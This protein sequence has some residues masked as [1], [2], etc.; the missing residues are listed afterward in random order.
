[1]SVTVSVTVSVSESA[2]SF[3]LQIRFRCRVWF[4][5]PLPYRF[6]FLS[7][8]KKTHHA[9]ALAPAP[10]R[11]LDHH[12]KPDALALPRRLLGR[13][14]VRLGVDL[15]RDAAI[16]VVRLTVSSGRQVGRTGQA[17]NG[18]GRVGAERWALGA[19][20]R[21]G[22]GRKAVSF[23]C[24]PTAMQITKMFASHANPP[25]RPP[26]RRDVDFLPPRGD[27]DPPLHR[28]AYPPP[29]GRVSR[30]PPLNS[31]RKG[32]VVNGQMTIV[33]NKMMPPPPHW[34]ER[35]AQKQYSTSTYVQAIAVPRNGWHSG[36]LR[37]DGGSDLVS[38][39]SHRRPRRAARGVPKAGRQAGRQASAV[40][41]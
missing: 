32:C 19:G 33:N 15:V 13:C 26:A 25:P 41:V 6:R 20:R 21:A 31:S 39:G 12:R 7:Q 27:T 28:N 2:S 36:G 22:N 29:W 11:R 10:L 30:P 16:L 8:Q 9:D 34:S 18:T 35:Q 17:A 24:I 14:H 3:R 37:D 1:M 23:R 5:F 4:R 40:L 38:Q